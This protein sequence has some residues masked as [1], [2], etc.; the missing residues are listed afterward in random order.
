MFALV[1]GCWKY[2][3][4]LSRIAGKLVRRCARV[5]VV[6]LRTGWCTVGVVGVLGGEIAILFD[7]TLRLLE[8]LSTLTSR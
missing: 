4:Y 6:G 7:R 1:S 3:A 8:L 5:V 2:L